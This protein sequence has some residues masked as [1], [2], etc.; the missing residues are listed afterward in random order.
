MLRLSLWRGFLGMMTPDVSLSYW[1]RRHARIF[2]ARAFI[3]TQWRLGLPAIMP[4]PWTWMTALPGQDQGGWGQ[5][6]YGIPAEGQYMEA[7]R[8]A[9][10]AYA[11]RDG[12]LKEIRFRSQSNLRLRRVYGLRAG[13]FGQRS[14]AGRALHF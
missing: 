4:T 14:R 1:P 8:L 10:P 2:R 3:T 9:Q 13:H 6:N 11:N 7:T 5:E 12:D